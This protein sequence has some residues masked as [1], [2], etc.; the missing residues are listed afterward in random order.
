[1]TNDRRIGELLRE[2]RHR[3]RLTQLDLA[4]HAEVSARH[5]S[6]IETGRTIP[7]SAMVLHLAERLG[8]PLRERNRL[9]VAAGHAPVFGQHPLDDPDLARVRETVQQVLLG[10][11]PYPA[12]A[13]DRHWNLLLANSAVEVFLQGA[14]PRL[15]EPPINMMRLGLHPNGLAQRLR[16]LDQVRGYLLPRLAHQAA[17]SGDPQLHALYEELASFGPDPEPGPPDP[18]E[19]ALELRIADHGT[20]LCLINTVTTFGAAFDVAVDEIAVEAYLPASPETRSFFRMGQDTW[21]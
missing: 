8:I 4:I 14:D 7:S 13:V 3:S 6:F 21:P 16:N 10:H 9:L 18:A 19:I 15:L 20:E 17:R 1:M 12:L 11:E 2:W 5:I